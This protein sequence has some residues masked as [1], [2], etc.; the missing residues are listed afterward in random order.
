M[1]AAKGGM[2]FSKGHEKTCGGNGNSVI[3]FSDHFM[4]KN[5][6]HNSLSFRL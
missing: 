5:V 3:D 1:A 4:G 2:D 6:N